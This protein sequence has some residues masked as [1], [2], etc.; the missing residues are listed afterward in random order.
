MSKEKFSYG[1]QA[2]IEGVMMRGQDEIAVALRKGTDEIILD[3]RHIKSLS[4]KYPIFKLPLLRGVLA[5]IE[6]LVLGIKVLTYS[7]NQAADQDDEEITSKE[8]FFTIS[9]AFILAVVLFV[10]IPTGLAYLLQGNM[11]YF[12]QNFIEG[13]LRI[14]IFLGYIVAISRMNDIQRVFQYHGAEHKVIHAYEARKPLT[15][16]NCREY[17]PLHPRCGTSFLLIV[18]VLALLLF[19]FIDTENIWWRFSS[20]LLLMPIVAGTAYEL[21]KYTGKNSNRGWVKFLITPGLWLQKLTTKE[22]DDSQL[23]VAI[24]ALKALVSKEEPNYPETYNRGEI[25][26]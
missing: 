7:A 1:G 3:R 9:L 5:L 16:E 22:P 26:V 23:E 15:V 12:W 17:G 18:M 19:S 4:N 21:I 20:R 11:N 13:I 8:M 10:V 2:V 6:S 24:T 25:N 14:A